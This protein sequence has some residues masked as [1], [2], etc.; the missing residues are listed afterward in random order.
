ML[1]EDYRFVAAISVAEAISFVIALT[2]YL[3]HT[4]MKVMREQG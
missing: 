1:L 3:Y 4:P 2:L